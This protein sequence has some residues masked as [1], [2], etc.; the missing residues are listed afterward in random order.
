M[1][2]QRDG[3]YKEILLS[4]SDDKKMFY[5]LINKQRNHKQFSISEL[6]IDDVHVTS[7]EVIRKRWASYFERLA[8]PGEDKKFDNTYKSKVELRKPLIQNICEQDKNKFEPASLEQVIKTIKEMKN[9]KAAD[10][11][12]LTAEHIKFDGDVLADCLTS[13]VNREN[14]QR[15]KARCYN[16]SIQETG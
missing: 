5:K 12:G 2:E 7:A 10:M 16:S 14:S 13:V 4:H 9:N 3:L 11:S 6:L 15:F 8:T 1:A